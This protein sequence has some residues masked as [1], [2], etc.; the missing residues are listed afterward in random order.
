[1]ATVKTH[2]VFADG[3]YERLLERVAHALEDADDLSAKGGVAPAEVDLEGLSAEE[4]AWLRAFV[5]RDLQWLRGWHAAARRMRAMS[6]AQAEA[7]PPK[8]LVDGG[9]PFGLVCALCETTLIQQPRKGV[10][11]C[12]SCGSRLFRAV[13]RR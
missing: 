11:P 6:L 2:E 13:N 4:V 12:P 1:M 3:L 9:E 7:E 8:E 5:Q 10:E